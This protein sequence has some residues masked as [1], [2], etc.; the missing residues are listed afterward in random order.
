MDD[1]QDQDRSS[2]RPWWHEADGSNLPDLD[3]LLGAEGAEV[4]GNVADEALKLFLAMRDK[5]AA[6][7]PEVPTATTESSPLSGIIAQLG[8]T[9]IKAVEG[10]AAAAGEVR[11]EAVTAGSSAGQH[12]S[13]EPGSAAACAY[14]PICQ[15]IALIRSVPMETWQRL[16]AAV[17]DVADSASQSDAPWSTAPT[18]DPVVFNPGAEPTPRYES[19]DDFLASLDFEGDREEGEGQEQ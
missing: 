18:G 19:V 13:D 17:V 8:A 6:P 4:V 12:A 1:S 16:A 2:S 11:G 5:W 9:A 7:S 15:G 10:F 3:A 14:C